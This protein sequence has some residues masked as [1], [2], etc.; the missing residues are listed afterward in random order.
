MHQV[1]LAT[2]C[3]Y[4]LNKFRTLL[5]LHFFF[6]MPTIA[7]TLED[8][9]PTVRMSRKTKKKGEMHFKDIFTLQNVYVKNGNNCS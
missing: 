1:H 9:P 8:V 2:V 7:V 3:V 4:D 6:H 5:L